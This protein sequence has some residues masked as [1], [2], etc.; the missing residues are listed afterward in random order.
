MVP[1]DVAVGG[2]GLVP[3]RDVGE[4]V[5]L[6][7]V[8][9]VPVAGDRSG[10]EALP[11]DRVFPDGVDRPEIGFFAGQGGDIGQGRIE[12]D[13]P[14]AMADRFRLLDDR[15]VILG[16]FA[17]E[18]PAVGAAPHVQE[19]PG[20]VE[21]FRVPRRP[22]EADQTHFHRLMIGNIVPLPGAE[23]GVDVVRDPDG[24]VEPGPVA[25]RQ[26][27]LDGGFEEVAGGEKLS[28]QKMLPLERG[29]LFHD[30]FV[31][32]LQGPGDRLLELGI[33]VFDERRGRPLHEGRPG[34]PAGYRNEIGDRHRTVRLLLRGP[35]RVRDLH[36]RERDGLDG[37]ILRL[38]RLPGAP[39][40]K[41]DQ[42]QDHG[43]TQMD[44]LVHD[45][46]SDFD[47]H[48]GGGRRRQSNIFPGLRIPFGSK[49]LR[50]PFISS[51]CFGSRA[52][53]R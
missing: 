30:V 39:R 18:L 17:E 9:L 24:P 21:I 25:R 15:L 35:E 8:L 4:L 46:S 6:S 11:V 48:P 20:Q 53:G 49:T 29:R 52:S 47:G 23:D 32:P 26:A 45:S 14:D 28:V 50:I 12:I 22:V 36:V 44:V 33:G 3:G 10:D 2:A 42:G 38:P 51:I 41:Q 34:R 5:R 31:R 19:E 13:G 16:V 37:I 7:E 43:P 40:E 27:E 1:E